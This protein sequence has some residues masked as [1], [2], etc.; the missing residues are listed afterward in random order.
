MTKENDLDRDRLREAAV[1]ATG[2]H[3]Y[4]SAMR[5]VT[6]TELALWIEVERRTYADKKYA[7]GEGNRNMAIQA[8]R[9]EG[10]GQTWLNFIGNYQKRAELFGVQT[11]QGRQA[12][13]KMITTLMH[14]L[15]TAILVYGEMPKPGVPSG[16]IQ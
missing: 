4:E 6:R 1:N 15:E 7:E 10:L 9:D 16:E 8:M 3:G 12:L 2:K 13:G 14:C 5:D 11:P